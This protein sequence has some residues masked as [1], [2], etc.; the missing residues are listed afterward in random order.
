MPGSRLGPA[1]RADRPSRTPQCWCAASRGRGT[2]SPVR[3]LSRRDR[4]RSR[5]RAIDTPGAPVRRIWS[6]CL[7]FARTAAADFAP[8]PANRGS[9]RRVPDQRKGPDRGRRHAELRNHT[10]FIARRAPQAIL[11]HDPVP[12]TIATRSLSGVQIRTCVTRDQPQPLP[13]PRPAHRPLRIR[14]SA[15]PPRRRLRAPVPGVGTEITGWDRRRRPSCSRDKGRSKR[16]DH[17]VGRHAHGVATPLFNA[18]QDPTT[19]R[20]PRLRPRTVLAGGTA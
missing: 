18:A 2:A 10:G 6:M 16:L 11:L 12:L 5:P 8:Q 19:P 7:N 15:I 9:L 3:D 14:S 17:V 4:Q 20:P 1:I 13:P